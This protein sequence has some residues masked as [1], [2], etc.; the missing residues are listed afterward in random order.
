MTRLYDRFYASAIAPDHGITA[1]VLAVVTITV[2]AFA[3]I[4]SVR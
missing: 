1:T 4:L 3:A 2:A